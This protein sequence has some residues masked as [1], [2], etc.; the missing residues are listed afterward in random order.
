MVIIPKIDY[1]FVEI[2]YEVYVLE[3]Y[4][5]LV[6]QQISDAVVEQESKLKRSL[7]TSLNDIERDELYQRHRRMVDDVINRL[8]RYPLILM[9]WAVYERAINN[10]AIYLKER[11]NKK[12]IPRDIRGSDEFDKYIKYYDYIL[13]YRLFTSECRKELNKLRIVRNFIS[14]YNGCID[15]AEENKIKQIREIVSDDLRFEIDSYY[16]EVTTKYLNESFA[17]VKDEINNLIDRV[18][19][20]CPS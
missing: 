11:L 16:L 2:M 13:N 3:D 17:L 8:F 14:H 20:D 15:F 12:L 18:K 1:R 19:N 4:L 5:G 10:V 7:S 9:M 6:D